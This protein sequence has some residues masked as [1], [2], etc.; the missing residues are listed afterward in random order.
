MIRFLILAGYFELT[1]YL[2]M[3]GK[4]NQYI[5]MH[6]SYLAYISM[7]LSFVLAL[8]QLV[9]WM[10]EIKVESH[11]K[12]KG[13]KLASILLLALPLMVGWFF[14]RVSLDSQTVSAKGYHFPLAAG[15][16]KDIQADEGTSSQYLK[17]DTSAYFTQAAY[18]KEMKAAAKKYVKLDHIKVTT[19]NYMEVMEVIYDYPDEFVGKTL[20]YTGFVYQDPSQDKQQFL[21][22]FGIIHCI[23]DSG[24]YGMLTTGNQVSYP[25][26]TW[27]HA[28]GK[29]SL[30]YHQNLGQSLPTLE[31]TSYEK[32]EQ[33]SNPYVYRVF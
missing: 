22:R 3:T 28:K 8:V 12:T 10:K 18:S 21:F 31:L 17:P 4:L 1:M 19:E 27:V 29:I 25:D 32:V 6:Y 33:P 9:L 5:N 13:A 11:L 16:S 15:T 24:V 20:E 26:N 23:A 30:H 7:V 14:P 2:Q